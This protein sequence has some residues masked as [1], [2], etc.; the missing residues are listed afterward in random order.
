MNQNR[1]RHLTLVVCAAVFLFIV[2]PATARADDPAYLPADS[3]GYA[4]TPPPWLVLHSGG[5][6]MLGS[7]ATSDMLPGTVCATYS[8]A[9]AF[10]NPSFGDK[11]GQFFGQKQNIRCAERTS[12]QYYVVQRVVG[13]EGNQRYVV[14]LAGL[15]WVGASDMSPAIPTGIV[16]QK[17]ATDDGM[18][19][20]RADCP[21]VGDAQPSQAQVGDI[22]EYSRRRI[23]Q[24]LPGR[25]GSLRVTGLSG[26]YAGRAGYAFG[27]F[28][29]PSGYDIDSWAGVRPD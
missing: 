7:H 12:V 27:T 10:V 3:S 16:V 14:E 17:D 11:V 4:E 29:T 9:L 5:M 22:P 24:V 1:R 8:D 28:K 6:A 2:A 20:D 23:E 19:C 26:R 21:H 25:M 18:L 13:I 15:G